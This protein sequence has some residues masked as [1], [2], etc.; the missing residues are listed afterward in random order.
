[1]G[2]ACPG[3]RLVKLK[4]GGNPIGD[5]GAVALGAAL[6]EAPLLEVLELARCGVGP[7][8]AVALAGGARDARYLKRLDVGGNPIGD[9]AAP[10]LAG[11]A[12]EGGVRC[13]LRGCVVGARRDDAGLRFD[14]LHLC[15]VR[16]ETAPARRPPWR[17]R[18]ALDDPTDRALAAET[19]RL[20]GCRDGGVFDVDAIA[21][22]YQGRAM[23]RAQ[24]GPG[25]SE[26]PL[27]IAAS[28][29]GSSTIAS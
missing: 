19:L 14:W 7:K 21:V 26:D 12:L 16:S 8:G 25:A 24:R 5:A 29:R 1:M 10:V 27:K 2:L 3:S 22:R 17:F 4:L 11:L 18:F 15:A 9:A 13:V 20:A 28:P 6:S 23:R